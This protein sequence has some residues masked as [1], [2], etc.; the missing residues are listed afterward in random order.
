MDFSS[1]KPWLRDGV[2]V[3]ISSDAVLH[4]V[5]L[6]TRKRLGLRVAPQLI[7]ALEWLDGSCTVRELEQKFNA[8][9]GDGLQ[10][11]P[12]LQ[13]M[14]DNGIIVSKHWMEDSFDRHTV[15][16]FS[17]QLNFFLDM[18]GSTDAAATLFE[19]IRNFRIAIFGIGALG[20]WIALELMQMGFR[21]FTLV[22]P[23]AFSPD[24]VAR[25]PFFA[26]KNVG[27]SKA[28]V[29]A[30]AISDSYEDGNAIP[31]ERY[32]DITTDVATF[33]D[34]PQDLIINTADEPYIGATS[35]KLSR[36]CIMAGVPL[37][38]S[39]GFDAHLGSLGELIVPGKTPCSDCYA[40]Y[41]E[42]ALKNW[43]PFK[44]PV[45]NRAT[46]FGGIAPLSVFSASAAAIKVIR[47][48]IDPDDLH[49]GGRGEMLFDS[50]KIDSF[51]VPRDPRCP[52][53]SHLV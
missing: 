1:F 6:A 38:V 3:Y 35:I 23:A 7:D 32:L 48:L 12:L 42:E 46:G 45:S 24:D 5:Y 19:K 39:G 52:A 17:R 26:A 53:C 22:D 41:F 14:Y 11:R 43:K 29:V 49:E 21:N 20:G 40:S 44:H 33:F 25:H 4:F 27:R 8:K 10:F 15:E 51:S 34:G 47:Y 16:R 36:Y 37:L 31:V 13:Y 9:V 50:Y 18:T 28:R 30:N 2:D